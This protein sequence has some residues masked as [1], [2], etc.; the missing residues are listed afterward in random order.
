MSDQ[1]IDVQPIRDL[2]YGFV[3]FQSCVRKAFKMIL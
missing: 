2:K 1:I 3:L